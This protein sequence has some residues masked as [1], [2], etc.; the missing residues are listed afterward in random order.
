MNRVLV[1]G[2]GS[3]GQRHLRNLRALGID[4]LAACDPD[5]SRIKTIRQDLDVITFETLSTAL[6]KFRPNMVLIC[7]P[8]SLHVEQARQV[9]QAGLDLFIEKPL[10]H[11]WD[12]VE[13]LLNESQSSRS[14][15]QVGYNLRFH[16]ALQQI[17]QVV[18]DKTMGRILWARAEFGQYL[19]DWR[20]WQDYRQSYTAN[21]KLGGG[22]LL[23]ASHEI[24]YLMWLLGRPTQVMCMAG[25]VSNLDVDVEDSATV[26]FRYADGVHVD[27]HVDFIQ[28]DYAR[29]LKLV[30][31][32][33][34][35]VWDFAQGELR[36]FKTETQRWETF[37]HNLDNNEMYLAEMRHF[38]TCVRDRNTP[39][40]SLKEAAD[41]LQVVLGAKKA[42]EQGLIQELTWQN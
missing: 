31:E 12:N 16:P 8:P 38:L 2:T 7:T 33:G 28:R 6:E 15:V 22:I 17:K 3:I 24:D 5:L 26:L 20:P 1:I 37:T 35:L 14:I 42:A 9:I 10:S 21:Q 25:K 11:T 29:S 36:L 39:L 19:P 30:G 23:D 18:T 4:E 27:I 34:I 41:V 13:A 40:V 32:E